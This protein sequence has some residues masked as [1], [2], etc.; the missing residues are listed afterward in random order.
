MA[1]PLPTIPEPPAAAP[2]TPAQP[3]L[4]GLLQVE[5]LGRATANHLARRLDMSPA[6]LP[7][8]GSSQSTPFLDES[9]L[10]LRHARLGVDGYLA[11]PRFGYFAELDAGLGNLRLLEYSAWADVGAQTR[12]RAGQMRVPYSYNWSVREEWLVFPERSIATEQFR[13]D[14]D[15]GVSVETHFATDRVT[16]IAGGYNGGGSILGHND[17]LDPMLVTRI[18]ARPFG[19]VAAARVEGPA[20]ETGPPSMLVGGT[21]VANYVPTPPAYGYLSGTPQPPRQLVVD[22]N[23]DGLPDGI[24]TL[25]V[26]LD[27]KVTRR[28]FAIEAEGYFRREWWHDIPALQPISP[29]VFA[30][31]TSY[32]GLFGQVVQSFARG[33]A[34]AGARF[35]VAQLSPLSPGWQRYESHLCLAN[36]GTDY[37]CALP[38]AGRRFEVSGVV[39]FTVIPRALQL[40]GMYSFLRW[41]GRDGPTPAD[42][43]EHR[44]ILLMQS[45]F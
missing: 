35:A 5:Y 44:L 36:G 21:V 38:Y 20:D 3:R 13:Y 34:K 12:I 41:A 31:E 25:D 18:E 22:A 7:S 14:Y 8:A 32:W 17:N 1:A 24:T 30:P 26:E 37:S 43:R 28:G 45:F 2:R 15:I 4:D 27:A 16:L 29:T 9:T 10:L 6:P 39:A 23:G 19:P 42:P 40:S 33:R 11:S